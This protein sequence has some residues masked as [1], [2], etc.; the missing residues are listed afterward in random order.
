ML[1]GV[2]GR[3]RRGR[4]RMRWLDGITHSMD[5]SLSELR[6]LVMDREAWRAA[7]HGVAK[8][9]TRL[10]DWTELNWTECSSFP[11]LSLLKFHYVWEMFINIPSVIIYFINACIFVYYSMYYLFPWY[12]IISAYWQLNVSINVIVL[13]SSV[14]LESLWSFR[15]FCMDVAQQKLTQYC[16]TM[17]LF[18]HQVGSDSSRC[19]GLKQ[20]YSNKKQ[21]LNIPEGFSNF[22]F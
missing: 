3:R 7:I 20:Q 15:K 9:R 5:V 6:E 12:W 16:D 11:P 13:N 14:M 4:H 2:V 8:S 1:V 10:S 19:H 21:W 18:S 22:Y 17:L